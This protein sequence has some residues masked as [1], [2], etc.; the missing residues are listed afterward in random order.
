MQ[1]RTREA[2]RSL[3]DAQIEAL[4]A[5][6][7]QEFNRLLGGDGVAPDIDVDAWHYVAWGETGYDD[8]SIFQ[9]V[10]LQTKTVSGLCVTMLK[11]RVTDYRLSIMTPKALRAEADELGALNPAIPTEIVLETRFTR[12]QLEAIRDVQLNARFGR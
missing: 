3:Y 4:L 12:E 1:M 6:N 8:G 2:M 11:E 5:D 7:I 10:P 9:V